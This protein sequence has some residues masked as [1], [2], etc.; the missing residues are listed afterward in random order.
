MIHQRTA[1]GYVLRL[2]AGEE[3]VA[4]LQAFARTHGIGSA[5]IAGL[6]A[7]GPVDL[8]YFVRGSRE[9]VTRRFE[10][11]YE[12]GSLTGNLSRM[13]GEPFAHC[14]AVIGGPDLVAY[15]GHLFR[16]IVTVTCE[17]TLVTDARVL[18]RRRREDLGFNAL[19][20]DAGV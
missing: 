1:H 19:E 16:A 5:L 3:I 10:G 14:H 20:P 11:D 13:D 8:G 4:S 6:G 18:L 17:I 12:I 9:Y 7:A 2:D 15:T